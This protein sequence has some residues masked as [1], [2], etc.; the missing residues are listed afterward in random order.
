MAGRVPGAQASL[1]EIR[2]ILSGGIGDAN[3]PDWAIGFGKKEAGNPVGKMRA[4]WC[5]VNLSSLSAGPGGAI[6]VSHKLGRKP[7]WVKFVELEV[8]ENASPVPQV[9][10]TP[11]QRNKWNE[12]TARIDVYVHVGSLTNVIAWLWAG[13][14]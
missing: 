10:V 12:T 2:G 9:S 5:S 7:S 4:C 11:I 3:M 6:D 14:E 8:P 1:D 13:G